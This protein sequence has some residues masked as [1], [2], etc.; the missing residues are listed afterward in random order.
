YPDRLFSQRMLLGRCVQLAVG[1][2]LSEAQLGPPAADDG[3]NRADDLGSTAA[4]APDATLYDGGA[5]GSVRVDE[6]DAGPLPYWN[7]DV[8]VSCYVRDR[9]VHGRNFPWR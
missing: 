9:T 7:G 4:G 2:D 6:M 1:S 8:V 3:R 5:C